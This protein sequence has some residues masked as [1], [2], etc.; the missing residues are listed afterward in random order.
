MCVLQF[1]DKTVVQPTAVVFFFF[2]F[3]FFDSCSDPPRPEGARERSRTAAQHRTGQDRTGHVSGGASALRYIP[4]TVIIVLWIDPVT[5]GWSTAD[6]TRRGARMMTGRISLTTAAGPAAG[7]E[8]HQRAKQPQFPRRLPEES[9]LLWIKKDGWRFKS[10]DSRRKLRRARKR[11]IK[12]RQTNLGK[13]DDDD[14]GELGRAQHGKLT[15][16]GPKRQ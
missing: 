7:M 8:R 14:D 10:S 5:P 6:R 3:S 2:S 13:D 1:R 9:S 12:G 15:S 16:T 11:K 4:Y